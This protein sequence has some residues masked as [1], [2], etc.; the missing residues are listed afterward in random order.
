MRRLE[1]LRS[2]YFFLL[3]LFLLLL[4]LLRIMGMAMVLA[5]PIAVGLGG[6]PVAD[7]VVSTPLLLL[8][9]FLGLVLHPLLGLRL[10]RFVHAIGAAAGLGGH[11]LGSGGGCGGRL[12]GLHDDGL[13]PVPGHLAGVDV[14]VVGPAGVGIHDFLP[15]RRKRGGAR[16]GSG[17][18]DILRI[19]LPGRLLDGSVMGL[20]VVG[21]GRFVCRGCL[22]LLLR[23]RLASII[24]LLL[25]ATVLRLAALTTT[26]LLRLLLLLLMRLLAVSGIVPLLRLPSPLLLLRLLGTAILRL[27]A[28]STSVRRRRRRHGGDR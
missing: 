17:N 27:S 5:V 22:L 24:L 28:R 4:L 18:R 2:G 12:F 14:V 8:L 19:L 7:S 20:L 3:L 16:I 13:G 23:S 26:I 6:P 1:I 15:P 25:I 9:L 10:R 11:L 21:L